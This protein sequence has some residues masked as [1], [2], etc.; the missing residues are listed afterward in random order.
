M[1]DT[2]K[3]INTTLKIF[4]DGLR[5]MTHEKYEITHKKNFLIHKKVFNQEEF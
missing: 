4:D 1:N 2:Q 3:K 5:K